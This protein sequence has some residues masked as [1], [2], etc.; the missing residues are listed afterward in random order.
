MGRNK[1]S[2]RHSKK[3]VILWKDDSSRYPKYSA[4]Y[5]DRNGVLR[6]TYSAKTGFLEGITYILTYEKWKRSD[7]ELGVF[8]KTLDPYGTEDRVYNQVRKYAEQLAKCK[9]CEL[10]DCTKYSFR[11]MV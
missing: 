10:E 7:V 8:G 2:K 5:Y 6:Q 3:G 11:D 4:V 9:G 1:Y